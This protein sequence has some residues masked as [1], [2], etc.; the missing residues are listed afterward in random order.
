MNINKILNK[1][2]DYFFIIVI[3]ILLIIITLKNNR[4]DKLN[5]QLTEKPKIEYI[6]DTIPDSIPYPKPVPYEVKVPEYIYDTIKTK[7]SGKD[8][9][10][11]A[12][13]YYSLYTKYATINKYSTILK[14]DSIAFIQLDEKVQYNSIFDR[15]LIFQDRTPIVK[16]TTT[17]IQKVTSIIGGIEAGLNGVELGTGIITKDN[18]LYKISYDP[19][20]KGL[21]GAVYF[22]IFNFKS[23]K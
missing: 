21:R 11:I 17:K 22:P 1:I 18:R 3:G 7:L 13:E 19:Y 14:N 20:N 9:A 4:I 16:I 15:N 10:Q 12:N 6:H 5:I 2:K 8:S 23:S